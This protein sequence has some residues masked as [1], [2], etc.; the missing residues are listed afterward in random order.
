ML[1]CGHISENCLVKKPIVNNVVKYVAQF[2]HK[3]LSNQA[4]LRC[5]MH[6]FLWKTEHDVWEKF[7]DYAASY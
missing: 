1:R 5:L 4:A 7:P 2:T 6:K 3:S